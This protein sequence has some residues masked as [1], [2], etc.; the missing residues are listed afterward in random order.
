MPREGLDRLVH[1]HVEHVGDAARP[2]VVER[3][4]DAQDFLLITPAAA[5]RAGEVDVREE[6]HLDVLPA[7]ARA[8]RAAPRA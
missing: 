5:G 2:P 3:R 4:P 6:L 7:R 1:G 8:A